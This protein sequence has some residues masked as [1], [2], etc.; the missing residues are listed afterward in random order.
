MSRRRLPILSP[1]EQRHLVVIDDDPGTGRLFRRI[2]EGEGYEVHLAPS[3]LEARAV[4]AEVRPDVIIL[5][6]V[7]PDM[8]GIEMVRWLGDQG[9]AAG[10]IL[11]SG[12]AATYMKAAATLARA[13]G[14]EEVRILEKP[15]SVEELRNAIGQ[16]GGAPA[17]G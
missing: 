13:R 6:M 9:Y 4:L 1:M 8:D 12:F 15:V 16:V 14:M 17:T 7:M 10:L 2:A 5:D 3:A 11:V